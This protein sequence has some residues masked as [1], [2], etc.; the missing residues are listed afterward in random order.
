MNV[1]AFGLMRSFFAL[2]LTLP[3]AVRWHIV[4]AC[5]TG[6]VFGI[7]SAHLHGR[8]FSPPYAA[9]AGTFIIYPLAMIFVI[10][11]VGVIRGALREWN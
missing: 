1:F 8:I 5:L 9:V 7:A 10:A 11:A 6:F 4:L 2:F 3:R